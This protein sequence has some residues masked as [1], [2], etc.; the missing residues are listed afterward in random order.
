MSVS[1]PVS[2]NFRLGFEK[3]ELLVL[4]KTYIDSCTSDL[5]TSVTSSQSRV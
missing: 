3:V 1:T 2:L 5:Q 4:C